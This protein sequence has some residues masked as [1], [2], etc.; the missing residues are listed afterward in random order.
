[1]AKICGWCGE[2]IKFSDM[3]YEWNGT[4]K[5]GCWVC[6]DCNKKITLAKK[7]VVSFEEIKCD[8]TVPTLFNH[9]QNAEKNS[10]IQYEKIKQDQQRLKEQQKVKEAAKKTDPLYD[11]IHQIAG[12]LRFIKNYLIICI[13]LGIILGLFYCFSIL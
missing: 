3:E 4:Y 10:A 2:K 11:D 12:D 13:I 8:K 5:E 9:Y 1:M 7:G 6:G